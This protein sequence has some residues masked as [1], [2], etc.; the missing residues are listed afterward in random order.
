MGELSID[1]KIF[2]LI[3]SR[4]VTGYEIAQNSDISEATISEI[5]KGN[6][7][8]ENLTIK[9]GR[10]LEKCYDEF[11]KIGKIEFDRDYENANKYY[12]KIK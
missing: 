12:K 10:S 6:R 4:S 5:R 3:F 2:I 7:L 8:I 1:K 11:E 9:K